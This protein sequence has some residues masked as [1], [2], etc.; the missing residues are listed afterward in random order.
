MLLNNDAVDNF[1]TATFSCL[2]HN[3]SNAHCWYD[4][5]PQTGRVGRLCMGP[6]HCCSAHNRDVS[7]LLK[8]IKLTKKKKKLPECTFKCIICQTPTTLRSLQPGPSLMN[9]RV[10][11]MNHCCRTI[12]QIIKKPTLWTK[13]AV[14]TGDLSYC[15]IILTSNLS[16]I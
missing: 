7:L 9:H 3:G 2:F 11:Q 8:S 15:K 12:L 16:S 4:V 1:L 5:H 10:S 13:E 6:N 14:H